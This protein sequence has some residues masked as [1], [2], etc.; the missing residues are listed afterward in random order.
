[1]NYE[2]IYLSKEVIIADNKNADMT[3]NNEYTTGFCLLMLSQL[4]EV[5]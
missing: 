1:M 5:V 3:P 4:S 2:D